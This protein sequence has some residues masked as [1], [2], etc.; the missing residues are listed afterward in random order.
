[1]LIVAE[2]ALRE[3][4]GDLDDYRDWLLKKAPAPKVVKVKE[5]KS[6]RKPNEQRIKRLE[7]LMTRLNGQK[8]SIEQKLADPAVYQDGEAVKALLQDQAYV[9][10]ELEQV[11][12][13]W[14]GL[15]K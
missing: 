6:I 5:K 15:A 7:E 10:K 1:L 9:A 4:D 8:V 12:F 2:G 13:E 11:E 3:F 14:L